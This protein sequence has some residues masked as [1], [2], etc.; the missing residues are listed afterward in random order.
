LRVKIEGHVTPD[1]IVIQRLD[2][3][4]EKALGLSGGDDWPR[5][6]AMS[7]QAN[8]A[9]VAIV[10]RDSPYYE[11]LEEADGALHSQRGGRQYFET[12]G[13]LRDDVANGY[14]RRT[15]DL[16]AAGVFGDFLDMADHLIAAGYHHPAASLV[17]AVLEDG[18]R[19]LSEKSS[20]KVKSGDD[21][22][23]LNNRLAA[24]TVYSNL[25]RRQVEVWTALR[26]AADHG[27]FTE[28]KAA[29]VRDMHTG[30]VRFLAEHLG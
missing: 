16:I 4:L 5:F 25:V 26:N 27:E 24:K 7:A 30:V 1:E 6:R 22:S 14:L 8:T 15:E 23:V 2:E 9:V 19:R 10:G 20:L 11:A 12:L 3:L 18:L 21:L 17:G 28:V 13:A 29:D